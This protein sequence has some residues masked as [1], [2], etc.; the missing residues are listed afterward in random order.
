M[1]DF[2]KLVGLVTIVYHTSKFVYK[3]G[4]K[5][6]KVFDDLTEDDDFSEREYTDSKHRQ[7]P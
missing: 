5:I 2:L 3:Y 4:G 1:N 6:A 7:R